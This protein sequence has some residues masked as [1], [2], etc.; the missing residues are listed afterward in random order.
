VKT[1]LALLLVLWLPFSDSWAQPQPDH[2]RMRWIQRAA[3]TLRAGQEFGD[4]GRLR[5]LAAKTDEEI[6]DH[7]LAQPEFGDA[8]LDFN[9]QFLGFRRERL[10]KPSGELNHLIYENPSAISSAIEVLKGGDFF[11]I[12]DFDQPMYHGQLTRPEKLED[13]DDALSDEQLRARHFRKIQKELRALIRKLNTN[14]GLPFDQMCLDYLKIVDGGETYN[15]LGMQPLF[16][17]ISTNTNMWIGILFTACTSSVK[18]AN[19]DVVQE[20]R[21]LVATNTRLERAL[22]AFDPARYS[23]KNLKDVKALDLAALGMAPK[24]HLF[25]NYPRQAL[26]NSS[27]NYN[28]RRGAYILDRFFCDDLTPVRVEIPN[29]HGRGAHGSE[30]ACMACHYK[31]DPMAGF[32]RDYGYLFSNFAGEPRIRFDDN[33]S[34]DLPRYQEAWRAPANSGREWE[35]GYIRSTTRPHLNVYGSTLEDLF[36]IIRK[37]PEVK[38]CMVKRM[39]EYYIGNKQTF[40][41]GYLDHLTAKFTQLASVNSSSAF[42]ELTKIILLSRGFRET[43]RLA[44]QCYDFAPGYNPAGKPPCNVAHLFQ[45]NC[46][47]CHSSADQYPYLDFSSWIALPDGTLNFRHQDA[48]GVQQPTRVTFGKINDRLTTE[49]S[50]KRMPLGR[51]MDALEREVL[52]KWVDKVLNP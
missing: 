43:D 29:E 21:K 26:M 23:T 38:R 37:E 35:V 48:T 1:L 25:G 46:V 9:L 2:E 13:G 32:F 6:V 15:R 16:T 30:P 50:A 33:A 24:W 41:A 45:K 4:R 10:R 14:P 44:D 49:N 8:V 12:L 22:K 42:K 51:H 5:A 17:D 40:D 19:L 27:T 18:P 20:L 34:G 36:G 11:K 52:F 39:L 31:L 28:R 47:L 7:F 3:R